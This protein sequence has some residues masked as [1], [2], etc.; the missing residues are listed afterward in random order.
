MIVINTEVDKL[1][2]GDSCGS[3]GRYCVFLKTADGLRFALLF[4]SL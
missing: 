3:N 1:A 4:C 2:N